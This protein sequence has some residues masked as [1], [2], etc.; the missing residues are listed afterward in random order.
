MKRVAVIICLAMLA[1]PLAAPAV[2][3][4]DEIEDQIKLGL[5]LYQDGKYNEAA[6]ELEFALAQL[7]QKKADSLSDIFPKAP[8]GWTAEEP[9]SESA[10]RSMLGG[11]ISASQT[12]RQKNG[13]G[14][15]KI[16]VMTDSPLIQSLGMILSNPMFMQG[17]RQVRL[18][19][20]HGQKGMLKR[21]GKK[22]FQLQMLING[23]V[24]MKVEAGRMDAADKMVMDLARK[25]DFDKLRK[26]TK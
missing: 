16:E 17:G 11:G 24:L 25:V 1:L 7:R 14:R 12:Y 4:A 21:Q 10:A 15:A 20:I 18:V 19:R 22:G 2:N 5:K 6:S 13:K 9:Q 26:I 23:K 8:Q 3:A